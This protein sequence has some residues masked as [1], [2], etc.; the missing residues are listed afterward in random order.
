MLRALAAE[1]DLLLGVVSNKRGR[2]LRLEA[3]A[4]GWDTYF[5]SLVGAN[6]ASLDKPAPEVVD[7][8]LAGRGI[9]GGPAV[10]IVGD[11]DIDILLAHHR[12]FTSVLSRR[13]GPAAGNF[14]PVST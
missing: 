11:T 4:L 6:D 14:R 3:A 12:R 5:E 10:W 13:Q 8:A 2:L 1:D 7:F 9:A